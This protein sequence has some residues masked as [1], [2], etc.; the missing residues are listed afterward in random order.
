MTWG[1][2]N[3]LADAYQVAS[4]CIRVS[5][6]DKAGWGPKLDRGVNDV[7]LAQMWEK[8]TACANDLRNIRVGDP[9]DP[10]ANGVP[11]IMDWA[12]SQHPPTYD[13]E[14]K[15]LAL[16]TEWRAIADEIEAV[17]PRTDIDAMLKKNREDRIPTRNIAA[18]ELRAVKQRTDA[19]SDIR[20]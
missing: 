13:I 3:S 12:K 16:E 19:L 17:M 11:G 14:S 2:H 4:H 15:W 18:S 6:T 9:D 5:E 10:N 7:T 8:A 20:D 1:P